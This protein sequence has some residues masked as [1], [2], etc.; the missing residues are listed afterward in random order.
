MASI[1]FRGIEKSFGPV[2]V[3]HGIDLAIADG[4][5]VGLVGPSGC[6]KSTLLRLLAGLDHADGGRIMIGGTEVGDR[7][8]KDR[9]MAMVF[10]R[11]A[12]YPHMTEAEDMG[13]SMPL[14]RK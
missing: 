8:G 13:L 11:Y 14:R 1:E 6:G 2:R 3:L 7:G 4:E 10:Q 9:D 5:F 12:L